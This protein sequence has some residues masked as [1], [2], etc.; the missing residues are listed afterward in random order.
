MWYSL[1]HH[2]NVARVIRLVLGLMIVY[3]GMITEQNG[4][5]LMGGFF[6]MFALFTT[7]CCGGTCVPQKENQINQT[8]SNLDVEYEEIK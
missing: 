1:T 5:I 3:Q 7:G 8:Q 4:V 2:W 6:S